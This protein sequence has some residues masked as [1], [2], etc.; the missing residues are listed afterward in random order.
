M[1]SLPIRLPVE[2]EFLEFCHCA[3]GEGSA[4]GLHSLVTNLVAVEVEHLELRQRPAGKSSG[5]GV[6][7]LIADL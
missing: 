3:A 7:A 6:Q 4:E 2:D 5:E 1:A